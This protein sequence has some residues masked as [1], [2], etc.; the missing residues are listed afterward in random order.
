MFEDPFRWIVQDEEDE[1]Y[2][3]IAN[4]AAIGF[5]G[6]FRK[7]KDSYLFIAHNLNF[8]TDIQQ[9]NIHTEHIRMIDELIKRNMVLI[10]NALIKANVYTFD[11]IQITHLPFD[12]ARKVD[13]T[14]FLEQNKKYV[15]SDCSL[16]QNKLLIRFTAND[17]LLLNDI[18]A[19]TTKN[20]ECEF[21]DRVIIL[22]K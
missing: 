4:K 17:D 8:E 13:N 2:K 9:W 12:Y 11:G 3:L 22:P 16:F 6:Y 19:S 7:I 20:V 18:M 15:Y 5:G 14:H 1:Q 21:M 10:E